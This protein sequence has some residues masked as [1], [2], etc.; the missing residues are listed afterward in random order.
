[1]AEDSSLALQGVT[2]GLE[3]LKASLGGISQ[4]LSQLAGQMGA[5]ATGISQM[6]PTSSFTPMGPQT[7]PRHGMSV[8]NMSLGRSMG[9]MTG[10]S[11][12]P[13]SMYAQEGRDLAVRDIAGRGSGFAMQAGIYGSGAAAA[14]YGM[15]AV[16]GATK[17]AGMGTGLSM[18]TAMTAGLGMSGYGGA[19]LGMGMAMG[20]TIPISMFASKVAEDVQEHTQRVNYLRDSSFRYMQGGGP[21]SDGRYSTGFN[22]AEA[23]KI[24]R[25]ITSMGIEDIQLSQGEMSGILDS[26]TQMG[27]FKG[28]GI[29][30]S[31]SFLKKFKELVTNVKQVSRTLNMSLDEGMRA[32]AEMNQMGISSPS[33]VSRFTRG[34]STMGAAGGYTSQ[35]MYGYGRMGAEM[36]RGSGINMQAG[37]TMMQ[38]NIAG[39][40]MLYNQGKLDNQMVAQ[41]GG[42][43]QLAQSMTQKNVQGINNPLMNAAIAGVGVTG[44]NSLFQGAGPGAMVDMAMGG[45]QNPADFV[46]AYVNRDNNVGKLSK[47]FGG[48]GI[49][50]AQLSADIGMANMLAPSMPGAS[51]RDIF[52][53][54]VM[55][56]RGLTSGEAEAYATS[57]LDN[58]EEMQAEF[59][60]Q[61][62]IGDR[63][64]RR[65]G[66]LR[67]YSI[68]GRIGRAVSGAY[69]T[70]VGDPIKTISDK[71]ASGSERMLRAASDAQ[72]QIMA[73]LSG[74]SVVLPSTISKE[75]RSAAVGSIDNAGGALGGISYRLESAQYSRSSGFGSF[76]QSNVRAL[77][78]SAFM[79][80]KSVDQA[81]H[82]LFG[83]SAGDATAKQR[84]QLVSALRRHNGD[85][86]E[87][88]VTRFEGDANA[89]RNDRVKQRADLQMDISGKERHLKMGGYGQPGALLAAG[90][91]SADAVLALLKDPDSVEGLKVTDAD[92]VKDSIARYSPE[93]KAKL[94]TEYEGL[95]KMK[96]DFNARTVTSE[97]GNISQK[98]SN[99]ALGLGGDSQDVASRGIEALRAIGG[100]GLSVSAKKA[101]IK[102]LRAAGKIEGLGLGGAADVADDHDKF[103]AFVVEL[104]KNVGALDSTGKSTAKV[105]PEEATQ[106]L[107]GNNL[108][109]ASQLSQVIDQFKRHGY[110]PMSAGGKR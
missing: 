14:W 92:L 24:A 64:E 25:G 86:A 45:L 46:N 4:G 83:V 72:I 108:E 30:D 8:N 96:G 48:R 87:A 101:Y 42:I 32:M 63:K 71:I 26:G 110:M 17:L 31:A 56:S 19:A 78:S 81:S 2:Q 67:E 65:E 57:H 84:L 105:D 100:G 66:L 12:A 11:A 13:H 89:G 39:L 102:D 60:R 50:M 62:A 41:A 47:T 88:A 94:I 10:L 6:F 75:A 74:E 107:A 36:V 5:G 34:T 79:R 9:M 53:M 18:N 68:G 16:L 58:Y 103:N 106:Q 22:R 76:E 28:A 104:G 73:R 61:G 3:S 93:K 21:G 54:S 35:E 29:N 90:G 52:K 70:L 27:L 55:R 40:S 98:L 51:K 44:L 49:E 43:E 97:I 77:T 82:A 85:L 80:A 23:G 38:S 95:Q 37:A 91:D 33:D 69:E 15:D 7:L 109:L 59:E 1:M 20:A 99:V